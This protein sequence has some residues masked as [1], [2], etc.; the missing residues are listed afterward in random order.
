[1]LR[2]ISQ[3]KAT[4]L[5][6]FA[7]ELVESVFSPL[8]WILVVLFF[9]LFY[10]ASRLRNNLLR[11]FLFWIP[12]LTVSVFCIAVVA[13]YAYMFIRFRPRWDRLD[14]TFPPP[15]SGPIG[16]FCQRTPFRAANCSNQAA[17]LRTP[18]WAQWRCYVNYAAGTWTVPCHC[19]LIGYRLR[20]IHTATSV[21]RCIA[22][23]SLGNVKG[24]HV[25]LPLGGVRKGADFMNPHAV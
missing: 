20:C 23:F 14:L 19:D 17:T 8:F 1:V 16:P 7:A 10:A 15:R 13:L 12:T 24:K 21:K 2:G 4:G 3:E 11:V 18:Q 9:A 22:V 5:A 25:K 6:A